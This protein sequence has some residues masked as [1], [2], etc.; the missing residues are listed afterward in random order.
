MNPNTEPRQSD[1]TD[2]WLSPC[3]QMVCQTRCEGDIS[4][5]EGKISGGFPSES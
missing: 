1:I 3:G 5:R 2:D 4:A